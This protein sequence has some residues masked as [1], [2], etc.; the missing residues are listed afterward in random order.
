MWI[1]LSVSGSLKKGKSR[2]GKQETCL[3]PALRVIYIIIF[4]EI[5]SSVIPAVK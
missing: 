1:F 3:N 2:K 4:N 5:A